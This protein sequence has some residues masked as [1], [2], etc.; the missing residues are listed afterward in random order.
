M[1]WAFSKSEERMHTVQMIWQARV[2]RGQG[3]A[4]IADPAGI[5]LDGIRPFGPDDLSYSKQQPLQALTIPSLSITTGTSVRAPSAPDTSLS[6]DG[7]WGPSITT[8]R[9]SM[10]THSEPS[11]HHRSP[12]TSR[13][14]PYASSAQVGVSRATTSKA[15]VVPSSVLV[16]PSTSSNLRAMQDPTYYYNPYG[17][18]AASEASSHA[19]S[20]TLA[21]PSIGAIHLSTYPPSGYHADSAVPYSNPTGP[22]DAAMIPATTTTDEE[23]GQF[24]ADGYY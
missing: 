6:Q 15:P 12:V 10:H 1:R 17:F 9:G 19:S 2:Q 11:P 18:P 7:S 14:P 5:H 13:T 16:S 8:V 24:V 21:S 20:S 3:L 23:E 22:Q 4:R